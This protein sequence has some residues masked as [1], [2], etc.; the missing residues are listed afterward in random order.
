MREG[1][2]LMNNGMISYVDVIKGW[3]SL[4]SSGQDVEIN[5]HMRGKREKRNKVKRLMRKAKGRVHATRG[6][7]MAEN[8]EKK[9]KIFWQEV[10]EWRPLEKREQRGDVNDQVSL[11]ED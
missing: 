7:C 9:T 5:E 2:K 11:E 1:K 8:Y 3:E 6:N 4:L 10:C